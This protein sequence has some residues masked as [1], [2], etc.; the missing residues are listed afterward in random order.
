MSL[1][2]TVD[3]LEDASP[4]G[5]V[6]RE[7][8]Q[9]PLRVVLVELAGGEPRASG[10]RMRS[11]IRLV[12]SLVVRCEEEIMGICEE[13]IVGAPMASCW[14]RS[15]TKIRSKTDRPFFFTYLIP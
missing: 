15:G 9:E 8:Q 14:S 12:S 6:A 10:S 4:A 1:R 5:A 13:E 7:V 11:L 3:G 2:S